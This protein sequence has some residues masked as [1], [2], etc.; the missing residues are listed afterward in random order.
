M[1]GREGLGEERGKGKEVEG[2][3]RGR[4]GMGKRGREGRI[5]ERHA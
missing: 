2:R 4:R 5:G 1:E 3:G